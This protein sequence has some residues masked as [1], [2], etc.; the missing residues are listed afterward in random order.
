MAVNYGKD[1]F[2]KGKDKILNSSIYNKVMNKYE[3]VKSKV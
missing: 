3:S 2:Q 1:I